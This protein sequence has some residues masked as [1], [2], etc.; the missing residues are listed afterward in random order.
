MAGAKLS[1]RRYDVLIRFLRETIGNPKI[2]YRVRMAAAVRLD[3][4]YSRHEMLAERTEQRKDRA[5]ARAEA[6]QTQQTQQTQVQAVDPAEPQDDDARIKAVFA[7]ISSKVAT[8]SGNDV[9][10]A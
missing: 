9:G 2:A 4:L 1:R 6:H 8:G 7:A 3:D 10:D 5:L